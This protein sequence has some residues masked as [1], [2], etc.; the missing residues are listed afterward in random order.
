MWFRDC[1]FR[2][3]YLSLPLGRNGVKRMTNQPH[4]SRPRLGPLLSSLLHSQLKETCLAR[5]WVSFGRIRTGPFRKGGN[6]RKASEGFFEKM[7]GKGIVI[8]RVSSNGM[9]WDCGVLKLFAGVLIFSYS[10]QTVDT[11]SM[12]KRVARKSVSLT[13]SFKRCC[14]LSGFTFSVID[15]LDGEGFR[16]V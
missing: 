3:I 12:S 13:L 6:T 5:P 9:R 11:L 16:G 1:V 14:I 2:I 15:C 7:N 4:V 10:A 8:T